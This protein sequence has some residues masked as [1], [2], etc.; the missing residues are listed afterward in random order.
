MAHYIA[1]L[2]PERGGGW[3]VLFPDLPGCATQGEDL[4]EAISMAVDA[5]AGHVAVM[6]DFGEEVPEPSTLEEVRK[7]KAWCEEHGVEWGKSMPA[8]IAVRAPIGTPERVTVSID[9]N[10][11]RQIDAYADRNGLTRSSVLAAGAEMLLGHDVMEIIR[12]IHRI[13][14]ASEEGA[15]TRRKKA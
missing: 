12:S 4:G 8:P 3:S 15:K 6:R 14:K 11:L 5:L 1:V 2:T 13:E 9:S 7:N 10:I